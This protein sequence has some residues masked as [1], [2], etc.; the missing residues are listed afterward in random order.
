MSAKV[1][2]V[3]PVYEAQENFA[4]VRASLPAQ[5]K[6]TLIGQLITGKASYSTGTA[7]WV[8]KEA[9]LDLGTQS[10]AFLKV[11]G[12][13]KPQS[14]QVGERA[15]GMVEVLSGLSATNVIAANAQFLVDSESFI[16]VAENNR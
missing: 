4:R 6:S 10:V 16:R 2:L 14:V 13:F 1:S 3:E 11:N 5:N 8:P 9:V 7:L 15:N 12:V